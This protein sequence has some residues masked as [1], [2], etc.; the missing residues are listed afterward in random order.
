MT[1]DTLEL[2]GSVEEI[3]VDIKE[4]ATRHNWHIKKEGETVISFET[5]AT[6]FSWGETVEVRL[7]TADGNEI[8]VR[9]KSSPTAQ[10]FDWGKSSENIKLLK[11]GLRPPR[12]RA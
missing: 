5:P 9:M 10:V 11:E 4:I 3:K 7:E 12:L 8:R 1:E 2:Q 6:I